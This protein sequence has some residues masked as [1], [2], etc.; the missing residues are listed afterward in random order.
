MKARKVLIAVVLCASS[1]AGC[2]STQKTTQTASETNVSYP[3]KTVVTSD[4]QNMTVTDTK[5]DVQQSSA[6]TTETKQNNPGFVVATFKA[7]GYVVSLPFVLLGGLLRG[8]FGG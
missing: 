3:N 8:I 6:S 7:I 1:I 5:T 2:A 4:G